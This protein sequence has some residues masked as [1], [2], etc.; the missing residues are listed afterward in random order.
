MAVKTHFTV[1]SNGK[2]DSLGRT[3]ASERLAIRAAREHWEGL[4][5]NVKC[6]VY[7][8]AEYSDDDPTPLAART[9]FWEHVRIDNFGRVKTEW[10]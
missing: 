5:E 8:H 6:S 1:G 9:T 4:P 2:T 3:F 7:G 10:L